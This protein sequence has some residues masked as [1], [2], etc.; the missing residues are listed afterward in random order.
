MKTKLILIVVGTSMVA[1]FAIAHSGRTDAKG[2][3][4]DN[5]NGGYHYHHG[6]SAHQHDNGVCPYAPKP[7]PKKPADS[8]SSTN[9]APAKPK[10]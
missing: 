10:K 1:T 7:A 5:K 3:H 6:Y 9:K 4:N 2:G 8:G